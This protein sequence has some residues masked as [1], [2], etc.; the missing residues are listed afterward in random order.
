MNMT[1]SY[2]PNNQRQEK[3]EIHNVICLQNKP[4]HHLFVLRC[5]KIQEWDLEMSPC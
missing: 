1:H 3:E 2:L 4:G 5:L